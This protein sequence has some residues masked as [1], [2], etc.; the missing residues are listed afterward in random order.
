[1]RN[2]LILTIITLIFFSCSNKDK[3]ANIYVNKVI[4][5]G[6]IKVND[7]IKKSFLIKNNS[8][9]DLKIKAI[10][11]SCGCTVAKLNDSIIKENESTD[12]IVEFVADKDKIGKIKN[13][14]VVEANTDPVFTV[15]YLIGSVK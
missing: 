12:L 3:T 9:V 15:L 8:S 6:L 7:T 14:I 4:N 1:M 10:K 13:S 11:S 5:F 2:N